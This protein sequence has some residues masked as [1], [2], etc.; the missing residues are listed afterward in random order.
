MTT[1]I[2]HAGGVITPTSM[3]GWDARADLRSIVHTIMGRSD[4]DI[5]RRPTGMRR[6][7]LTLVFES[8]AAAY[9]A[10]SILAVTQPLDLGNPSVGQVTM[11]FIVAGNEL[12]EVI[13]DAGQWVL[14]VPFQEIAS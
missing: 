11:R 5:T 8:G 6:G 3:P 12:G 2:T 4:P 9:A 14:S 10:R 13:E 1:T 7:T